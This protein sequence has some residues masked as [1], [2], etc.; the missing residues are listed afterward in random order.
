MGDRVAPRYRREG[1]ANV[2]TFP[3]NDAA[4]ALDAFLD[5]PKLY[6]IGQVADKPKS[7]PHTKW[8]I[9]LD[10]FAVCGFPR[11]EQPGAWTPTLVSGDPRSIGAEYFFEFPAGLGG[12]KRI[13]V[14]TDIVD[15]EVQA[16]RKRIVF[17]HRNESDGYVTVGDDCFANPEIPRADTETRIEITVQEGGKG[18]VKLSFVGPSAT[19]PREREGD[20]N[21]WCRVS[22]IMLFIPCF[23]PCTPCCVSMNEF[24]LREEVLE[25]MNRVRNY[26]NSYELATEEYPTALPLVQS[27]G[28]QSGRPPVAKI[29]AKRKSSGGVQEAIPVAHVTGGES[30]AEELDKWFRLFKN[31]AITEAEYEA[32]KRHLLGEI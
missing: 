21:F 3:V 29:D 30:A 22:C 23:I 31:G 11:T 13:K 2:F 15:L 24:I 32:K 4:R 20:S 10:T 17:K 1:N 14:R 28:T 16:D 18:S 27:I 12:T 19:D 5:V 7:S 25:Q 6:S 9:F 26:C 8:G